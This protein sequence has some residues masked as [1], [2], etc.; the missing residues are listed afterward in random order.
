[1]PYRFYCSKSN[2][3]ILFMFVKGINDDLVFPREV[4]H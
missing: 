2:R 1:M 4:L 3:K